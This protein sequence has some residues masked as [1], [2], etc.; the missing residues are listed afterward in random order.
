MDVHTLTPPNSVILIS[1]PTSA[2]VPATWR[3]GIVAA[4][5]SCIAV[6]TRASVDGPTSLVV[7]D[8]SEARAVDIPA[9]KA[10][11][12]DLH[13]A[14]QEVTV[15][16]V[17]GDQYSRRTATDGRVRVQVYVNHRT[18]PDRIVVVFG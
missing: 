13:V 1:D 14:S 10:F 6:G 8:A 18:E 4:T 9:M 2:D 17:V 3:E 15:E 11:D 5:D 7:V 12:G 16:S